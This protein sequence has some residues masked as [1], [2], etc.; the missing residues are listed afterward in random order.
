[1]RYRVVAPYV[2]VTSPGTPPSEFHAALGV[3]PLVSVCAPELLPGDVPAE[4][5]DHLLSHGLI[6]EDTDGWS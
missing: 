6:E 4:E 3:A 2:T 1:M 5:I